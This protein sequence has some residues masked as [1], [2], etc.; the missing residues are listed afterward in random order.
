MS[1]TTPVVHVIDDP[2]LL[3]KVIKKIQTALAVLD[4]ITFSFGRAFRKFKIVDNTKVS[5]PGIFQEWKKDY[6]SAFPNDNIE[7]GYSFVFA[8]P[9][10]EITEYNSRRQ[11]EIQRDI[12]VIV[13]FDMEKID[14]T[15]LYPFNEKLKEDIIFQ[16]DKLGKEVL[17]INNI[18][19]DI[20]EVFDDFTVSQIESQFLKER[21]G[22]FKFECTVFYKNDNCVINV[23][24]P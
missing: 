1:Q 17:Q 14:N 20:E 3:D 22:A 21:Y 13:F 12:S 6:Y 2:V 23:F 9:G 4:W 11:H 10:D 8:D 19:D 5:Y 7:K 16:L 15:L 18:I 24:I